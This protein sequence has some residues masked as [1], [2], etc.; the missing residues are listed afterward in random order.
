MS[1]VGVTEAS[2]VDR[3]TWLSFAILTLL[4]FG[5]I[6]DQFYSSVSAVEIEADLSISYGVGALMFSVYFA[7][8]G[9]AMPMMGRLVGRIGSRQGALLAFSFLLFG[10]L[11]S[12]F[13]PNFELLLLSRV[14]AGFALATGVPLIWGATT[15]WFVG[16]QPRKIA[17][18]I[19][20]FVNGLAGLSGGLSGGFLTADGLPRVGY[21][22]VAA[23]AIVGL[24][25]HRIVPVGLRNRA[26]ADVLGTFLLLVGLITLLVGISTGTYF[27]WVVQKGDVSFLGVTWSAGAFGFSPTLV[28]I[29]IVF[30]VLFAIDEKSARRGKAT[31]VDFGLF[32]GPR[33]GNGVVV[34]SL[35]T[36]AFSSLVVFGA[37]IMNF[38]TDLSAV[39]ESTAL[40]LFPVGLLFGALARPV[41]A[42]RCHDR[43][44]LL[45]AAYS[46][47]AVMILIF[48]L[49]SAWANQ[50]VA[51]G[52]LLIGFF[53]GLSL[54]VIPDI[55]LS[56]V[57]SKSASEASAA[58]ETVANLSSGVGAV[59]VAA[60][61]SFVGS[62]AMSELIDDSFELTTQERAALIQEAGYVVASERDPKVLEIIAVAQ[63]SAEL[64]EADEVAQDLREAFAWS[65]RVGV[66]MFFLVILLAT[67]FIRRM[68][69]DVARAG[70]VQIE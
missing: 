69:A 2:G 26:R 40:A 60:V 16:G 13:S 3:R 55:A 11:G 18:S 31:V 63:S 27:G 46:M 6:F 8:G 49:W 5:L 44:V 36:V 9:G 23:V 50:Q 20:V 37:T 32:R 41:L 19:V 28:I 1:D 70:P 34:L 47:M 42:K 64:S 57:R 15:S 65:W 29:G 56:E 53:G 59:I 54:S 39:T 21:L 14:V 30:L 51:A 25:L 17:F 62:F 4:M 10:M 67:V 58:M 22:V 68:T 12:A 33:F 52:I 61:V 66:S 35:Y 38:A 43:T 45:G 7:V 24:L 48:H